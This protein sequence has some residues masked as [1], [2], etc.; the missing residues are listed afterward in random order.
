VIR[1]GFLVAISLA[2]GASAAAAQHG[3]GSR[4]LRVIGVVRDPA[5]APVGG[6]VV[7][8]NMPRQITF[9]GKDGRFELARPVSDSAEIEVLHLAYARPRQRVSELPRDSVDSTTAVAILDLRPAPIDSTPAPYAPPLRSTASSLPDAEL[10]LITR[11]SRL[12]S[13]RHAARSSRDRQIRVFIHGGA[14]TPDYAV[15]LR[16]SRGRVSGEV[17]LWWML[18]PRFGLDPATNARSR[19]G[20]FGCSDAPWQW[21]TVLEASIPDWRAVLVCRATLPVTPDWPGMWHRLDSLGVWRLPDQTARLHNR[22]PFVTD[23]AMITVEMFNGRAYRLVR[24][25]HPDSMAAPGAE[26][27]AAIKSALQDAAAAVRLEPVRWTPPPVTFHIAGA[28]R[29]TAGRPIS[30]ARVTVPA[31]PFSVRTAADGEFDVPY[32]VPFTAWLTVESP[33][34]RCVRYLVHQ[35]P[36]PSYG[37][38]TRIRTEIV[39]Q[40]VPDTPVDSVPPGYIRIRG[41]SGP[42]WAFVPNSSAPWA[43][44]V[45]SPRILGV[46]TW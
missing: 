22:R 13:L 41:T 20:A 44:R 26:R 1:R 31:L 18:D 36:R 4:R 25:G 39:L 2:C 24:Q 12:P 38:G 29:D 34:Y 21:G 30:G 43:T 17:W 42:R 15:M 16:R 6:A 7:W 9:T 32:P 45:L 5:G 28:V 46:A 19:A 23:G 27:A 33:G 14:G 37:P 11:A 3:N 8:V 40:V 10:E 35:L